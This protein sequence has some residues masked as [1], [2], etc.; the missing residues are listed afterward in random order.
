MCGEKD[1]QQEVM[2]KYFEIFF[3]KKA[4][5]TVLAILSV[6]LIFMRLNL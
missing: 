4:I 2:P 6:L 3:N 1:S 5:L